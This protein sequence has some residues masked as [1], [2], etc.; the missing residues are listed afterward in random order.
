M[1]PEA[2]RAYKQVRAVSLCGFMS[3]YGRHRL[4]DAAA[5][6]SMT[7]LAKISN[8]MTIALMGML[9]CA[10]MAL[11]LV[12]WNTQFSHLS[13][14]D[15]KDLASATASERRLNVQTAL[16]QPRKFQTSAS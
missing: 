3:G 8:K 5:I 1:N 9:L 12:W 10:V 4:N 11:Y 6:W 14:Y 15:A 13:Y 2:A 7:T 16:G